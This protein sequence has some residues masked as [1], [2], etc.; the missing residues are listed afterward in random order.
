MYR[1]SFLAG[2]ITLTWGKRLMLVRSSDSSLGDCR[3]DLVI[4]ARKY[5]QTPNMP[6]IMA[7]NMKFVIVRTSSNELSSKK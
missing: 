1:P 2:T 4:Y 5:T 6:A 7:A 3:N